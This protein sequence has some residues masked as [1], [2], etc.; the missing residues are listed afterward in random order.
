MLSI[1]IKFIRSYSTMQQKTTDLPAVYIL[2][3]SRTKR[4]FMLFKPKW[5]IGTELSHDVLNPTHVPL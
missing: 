1:I 4:T 5:Q 2:Q 3:S